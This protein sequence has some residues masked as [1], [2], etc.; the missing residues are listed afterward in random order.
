MGLTADTILAVLAP[1]GVA[2]VFAGAVVAWVQTRRGSQT[3]RIIRP[4]GSEI[5]ITSSHVRGL[6]A[7]QTADLARQLAVSLGTSRGHG[8]VAGDPAGIGPGPDVGPEH[9]GSSPTTP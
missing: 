5:T 8:H 1:G 3:V 6:D 9:H 4:D 2:A 7:R